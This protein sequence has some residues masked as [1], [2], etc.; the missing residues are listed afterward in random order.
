MNGPEGL[1]SV[2]RGQLLALD[3]L[4]CFSLLATRPVGRLVFTYRALPEVLPVNYRMDGQNVL[5]RL[6]VGS[7]AARAT[8]D[9]V[10][11]FEVD[12]IDV[13][14]RSGWSV[15][16]V[17]HA[18]EIVDAAERERVSALDLQSWAGDGRDHYLGIAVEKVTGRRLISGNHGPISPEQSDGQGSRPSP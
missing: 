6:A 13:P 4:A 14:G 18:R 17:G 8:K 2:D 5:I 12:D 7:T 1:A 16:V 11:A 3:R 10:V 15:T 9:S